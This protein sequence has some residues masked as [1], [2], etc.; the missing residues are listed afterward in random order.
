MP[1]IKMTYTLSELDLGGEKYY[2]ILSSHSG[3]NIE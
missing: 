1:F 2:G 3:G